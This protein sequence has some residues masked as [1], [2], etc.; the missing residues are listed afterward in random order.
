MP[1]KSYFSK[2]ITTICVFGSIAVG[3]PSAQG[4]G[5]EV[6]EGGSTLNLIY[7]YRSEDRKRDWCQV[8]VVEVDKEGKAIF[9]GLP[10]NITWPK[11]VKL[12]DL[13]KQ[14]GD[15]ID[16][17]SSTHKVFAVWGAWCIEPGERSEPPRTRHKFDIEVLLKNKKVQ[18]YKVSGYK[19]P[20]ADW[21]RY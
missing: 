19:I 4:Y 8:G 13:K 2:L 3:S 6:L 16:S 20:A 1:T 15:P 10:H 17:S 18:A 21:I 11:D 12:T 7:L 14:L 5:I 9:K